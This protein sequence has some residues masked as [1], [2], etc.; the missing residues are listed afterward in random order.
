MP[1]WIDD[2]EAALSRDRMPSAESSAE[3]I[4]TYAPAVLDA[5]GARALIAPFLAGFMWAALIFRETQTHSTLEPLALLLRVLAYA[6][7]LRAVRVSID[8][9]RRVRLALRRSRYGLVLTREGL[10]L[11]VPGHDVVIPQDDVLDIREQH[12]SAL[13]P[14]A[15]RRWADVYVVTRPDT[16]RLFVSLPPIFGHSPRRLAEQLMRWHGVRDSRPPEEPPASEQESA[17]QMLPSRLWERVAHGEQF[18]GVAAIRHGYG[19]LA[20]GPYASMLLGLA[21]LDGYVRLPAQ[22]SRALNPTPALLLA[23]ALVILPSAW[24]LFTRARLGARRGLALIVSPGALLL[25]AGR[26][27]AVR[28]PW[29]SVTRVETVTRTSWSLLKGAHEV[30]TL[31]AQRKRETSLQCPADFMAVPIE[32]VV[33]LCEHYRKRAVEA[34]GDMHADDNP[35]A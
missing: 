17:D 29:T 18:P 21:V 33:G 26:S 23:A 10:L 24:V 25:R 34:A 16:G 4:E 2:A 19:W 5:T 30:R 14:Q 9:F 15:T 22:A 35:G 12:A 27:G 31:V 11:R 20:R 3:V 7:T 13:G 28:V 8:L 32:V 6:L 1:N